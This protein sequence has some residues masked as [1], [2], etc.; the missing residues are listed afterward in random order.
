M[1]RKFYIPVLIVCLFT[2]CSEQIPEPDING[3]GDGEVLINILPPRIA[4]TDD[5]LTRSMVTE[6]MPAGSTIRLYVYDANTSEGENNPYSNNR[7]QEKEMTFKV[8]SQ[9]ER[10]NSSDKRAL[11]PWRVDPVTGEALEDGEITHTDLHLP[12]ALYDFFAISPA[13]QL[14]TSAIDGYD[15]PGYRF[16]HGGVVAQEGDIPVTLYTSSPLKGIQISQDAGQV[17]EGTPGVYNLQ[18]EP[19]TLLSSRIRFIVIR[20]SDVESM[21]IENRGVEMSN[22]TYNAF[23]TNFFIGEQKLRETILTEEGAVFGTVSIRNARNVYQ[24]PKGYEDGIHEKTDTWE[25][26]SEVIPN[27][28]TNTETVTL[29]SRDVKLTFHLLINGDN[30]KSYES[31]LRNQRFERGSE[32]TYEV[33]V[34]AGGIFVRGWRNAQWTVTIP[35]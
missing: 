19:F 1:K 26:I 14:N 23:S 12:G 15:V 29:R 32:Y 34:N 27:P 11:V 18:L 6:A 7:L 20:G 24:Q 17:T 2:A 33:T 22:M 25:L 30:Y 31:V 16:R 10:N 35:R 5:Q 9:E 3:G 13:V 21:R 4:T 28:D 8:R